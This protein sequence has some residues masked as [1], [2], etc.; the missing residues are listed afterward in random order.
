MK[1]F[2]QNL[3]YLLERDNMTKVDLEKKIKESGRHIGDGLIS[4]YCNENNDTEPRAALVNEICKVFAVDPGEFMNEDMSKQIITVREHTVILVCEKLINETKQ[5]IHN[6][7]KLPWMSDDYGFS[8]QSTELLDDECN[9]HSRFIN[10]VH[11]NADLIAYTTI[12]DEIGQFI[13]ILFP[14]IYEESQNRYELYLVK[15]DGTVVECCGSHSESENSII[16]N[17]KF[18]KIL[19]ELY[20]LTSN[21]QREEVFYRYLN[22]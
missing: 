4:K 5:N 11:E 18:Y 14:E 16:C 12:I 1:Y 19:K 22:M 6:W 9:F 7:E 13:I 2:K 8:G 20:N 15:P 10:D 21:Y 3:V 17:N